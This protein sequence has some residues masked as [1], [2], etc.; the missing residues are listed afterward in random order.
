MS[1]LLPMLSKFENPQS[2]KNVADLLGYEYRQGQYYA[3]ALAYI[4]LVNVSKNASQNIYSLSTL[5]KKYILDRDDFAVASHLV[6]LPV[7][8][9]MI[10]QVLEHHSLPDLECIKEEIKLKGNTN[11]NSTTMHRRAQTVRSILSWVLNQLLN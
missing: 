2:T 10:N 7:F 8:R 1:L 11:L 4:G 5:G 6:T 3:N 9:E